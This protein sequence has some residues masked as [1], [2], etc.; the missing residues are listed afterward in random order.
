MD[1]GIDRALNSLHD[2]VWKAE[3]WTNKDIKLVRVTSISRFQP[4]IGGALSSLLFLTFV[5][6]FYQV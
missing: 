6:Q 2:D 4:F 3:L 1:K 5:R